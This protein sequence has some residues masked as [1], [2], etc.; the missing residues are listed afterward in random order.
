LTSPEFI[1][2]EHFLEAIK[3]LAS[4]CLH[5]MGSMYN[6]GLDMGVLYGP[7]KTLKLLASSN[8]NI[9]ENFQ[10]FTM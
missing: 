10:Q 6:I 2:G 1:I 4:N 7:T 5:S 9:F 3:G 8:E